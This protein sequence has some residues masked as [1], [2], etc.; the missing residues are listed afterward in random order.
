MRNTMS[1]H[2]FSNFEFGEP[3]M[4]LAGGMMPEL[5][6]RAGIDYENQTASAALGEL[7]GILGSNKVTQD[8]EPVD[9]LTADEMADYVDRAGTQN[10]LWRSL[11]TPDG[12][13]PT[14][15]NVLTSGAVANWQ[16]RVADH[17]VSNA[18]FAYGT[19]VYMP[20]GNRLMNSKT[21]VTNPN[22]IDF[23][24]K[25]ETLP[26][27]AQYAEHVI[28][29]RLQEGNYS[30]VLATYNTGDG[31]RIAS[32]FVTDYP[33]LFA[34][35]ERM[36]FVRV[37]NAGLQLALQFRRAAQQNVAPLYDANPHD[38]QVFI[39]TDSLQVARNGSIGQNPRTGLR[40]VGVAAKLLQEAFEY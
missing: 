26:T 16:D 35:G 14:D 1:S 29:P 23:K 37:A 18:I 5:M 10:A 17:L 30:P 15:S 24:E 3:V 39:E 31:E 9:F 33:E 40:Q 13:V 8:N 25:F 21:E 28:V 4:E 7:V 38:P 22:V 12:L 34:K 6:E 2:D 19:K 36:S 20:V 11:W 32:N 27:E